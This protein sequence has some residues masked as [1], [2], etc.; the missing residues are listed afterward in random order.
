MTIGVEQALDVT[1]SRQ[2]MAKPAPFRG[3]I[4]LAWREPPPDDASQM[5]S[6]VC[7]VTRSG[8]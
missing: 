2:M 4:R 6:T 1:P 7:S 8:I 5:T 3:P